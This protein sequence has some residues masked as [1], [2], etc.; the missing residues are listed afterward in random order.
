MVIVHL[1]VVLT[2]FI[3]LKKVHKIVLRQVIVSIFE[4]FDLPRIEDM[5][6]SVEGC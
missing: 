5:N 2:T 3:R 6:L 1:M 4:L